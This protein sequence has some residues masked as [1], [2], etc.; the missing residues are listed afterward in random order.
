MV[1]EIPWYHRWL[2]G[3]RATEDRYK[4]IVDTIV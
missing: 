3:Q 1:S 2:Q 4:G